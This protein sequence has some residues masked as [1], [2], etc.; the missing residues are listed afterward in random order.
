MG[1]VLLRQVVPAPPTK[2]LLASNFRDKV[3]NLILL[4][5]LP[6]TRA[7]K[8]ERSV[9]AVN[10]PMSG[11]CSTQ[12]APTWNGTPVATTT[13]DHSKRCCQDI[14]EVALCVCSV[15]LH[16][17]GKYRCRA[18]PQ[19]SRRALCQKASRASQQRSVDPASQTNVIN[20]SCLMS[21]IML[22]R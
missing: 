16:F 2:R 14:R 8:V 19:Y 1:T 10:S 6:L 5:S 7:C 12:R 17:S 21:T 9:Y 13:G 18:R 22:R 3:Q 4:L 20:E 11:T 15:F